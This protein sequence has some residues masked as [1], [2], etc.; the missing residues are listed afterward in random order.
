VCDGCYQL[1]KK[2]DEDTGYCEECQHEYLQEQ[3]YKHAGVEL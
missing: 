1:V 2:V 3:Y